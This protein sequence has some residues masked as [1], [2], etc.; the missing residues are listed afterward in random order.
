MTLLAHARTC[1]ARNPLT[2]VSGN[3]FQKLSAYERL[4]RDRCKISTTRRMTGYCIV[5]YSRCILTYP[6]FGFK[7]MLMRTGLKMFQD[8]DSVR[9]LSTQSRCGIRNP[10]NSCPCED[11][12]NE[13]WLSMGRDGCVSKSG[14]P[15]FH[16]KIT[17]LVTWMFIHSPINHP[18]H[19]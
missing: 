8:F 5:R 15:D 2:N 4:A 19:H 18:I 9:E 6:N 12:G 17:S 7:R 14:H 3:P 1:P 10:C 16:C 11:G 13:N